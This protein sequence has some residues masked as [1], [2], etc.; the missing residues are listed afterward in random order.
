MVSTRDMT[1][2]RLWHPLKM[3]CPMSVCLHASFSP[4]SCH[5]PPV[6]LVCF[7]SFNLFSLQKAS[8]G[9]VSPPPGLTKKHLPKHVSWRG[10]AADNVVKD[11]ATCGSCWVSH[12][13][14]IVKIVHS[15]SLVYN[16]TIPPG[17]VVQHI[18]GTALTYQSCSNRSSCCA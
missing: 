11:Q 13:A 16:A 15:R 6:L 4:V 10:T 12:Y 18:R 3:S 5:P 7:V 1:K 17:F 2:Q 14:A 8:L 9:V